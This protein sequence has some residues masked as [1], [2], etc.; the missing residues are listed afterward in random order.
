MSISLSIYRVYYACLSICQDTTYS[1]YLSIETLSIYLYV[2]MHPM[3]PHAKELEKSHCI[4]IYVHAPCEPK[5]LSACM[6][7]SRMHDGVAHAC[8]TRACMTESRTHAGVAR[9]QVTW[10]HMTESM[11]AEGGREGARSERGER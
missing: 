5:G 6:Q 3:S 11:H 8:S 2:Y 10:H 7:E 4:C 1:I 9:F